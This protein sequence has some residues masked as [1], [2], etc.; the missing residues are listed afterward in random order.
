M[1]DTEEFQIIY[2]PEQPVDVCVTIRCAV[3]VDRLERLYHHAVQ[4]GA[5]RDIDIHLVVSVKIVAGLADVV[6]SHWITSLSILMA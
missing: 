4:P 6:V 1:L 5:L 3:I 2:A